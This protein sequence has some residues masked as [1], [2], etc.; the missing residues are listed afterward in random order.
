MGVVKNLMVRVG[1]D[2]RGLV[3]GMKT[4]G[5]ATS[6]AAGSIKNASSG[7]QKSVKEN[8][9]AARISVREY[10]EYVAKTKESHTVAT[11]NAER[12]TDKLE[13]LK[14]VFGTVQN[15]TDG[16]DMS[17]PLKKQI[18]DTEKQ[19]E[20]INEKIYRTSQQI[21]YIGAG[22]SAAKN[23]RLAKLKDQLAELMTESD[24]TAAHLTALD[25]AAENV[26]TENIDVASAA[27]LKNLQAEIAE[28][29]RQLRMAQAQAEKTGQTLHSMG[30]APTLKYALRQIGAAAGSAVSGGVKKLS[31][32][33][34][35]LGTSA[36]RGIASIPGKLLGIGKSASAST[37][38]L[39]KMVRSIRNIG[40]VSMGMKVASGLFGQLR[41]I[42]SSYVSQNETLNASVT[43][44]KNQLGQA[45]APAINIV[46]AAMQK[47]MPVVT[48]VANA[49]NSMF[50]ALF[51]KVGATTAAITSS[52][53]AA[54]SAADSL[55]TYGFDQI[56]KVSDDSSGGSSSS[57]SKTSEL[58]TEQ[59]ALIQKL[60]GWIQ[61][62]K[63]AFVAGDWEGL[64]QVV[65][66]GIN[67]VFDSINAV[68]VGGK[69]GTFTNNLITTLNSALS[70]ANFFDIGQK[71]GQTFTSGLEK[72]DWKQAG[73]TIGKVMT[74]LPSIIIGFIQGTNWSTVGQSLSQ[75]LSGVFTSL[76]EWL[77]SVDW[78]NI[79]TSIWDFISSIDYG[80]I[81]SGLFS[82]LGTALGAGV[83]AL[84]GV[85]SG[86]VNSIKE[87]FTEKIQDCGGNVVE[88]LFKGILDA[89]G[90]IGSWI[91]DNIFTPFVEGFKSI[92]GIHSPSTV[93]Q[94]QGG[95]L[96]SGLFGGFSEGWEKLASFLS[97]GLGSIKTKLGEAWTSCRTATAQKWGEISS[98]VS[99]KVSELK[100]AASE[101]FQNIKTSCSEIW[102]ST[103]S[104]AAQK[105]GEISGAVSGKVSELKT[106][107]SEKFQNIK[108]SCSEIWSSMKSD[109]ASAASGISSNAVSGFEQMKQGI[110]DT[111]AGVWTG[112][113]DWINKLIGG[114]ESMV[115]FVI[116]GINRMI[117]SFNKIASVGSSFGINL[118]ISKIS[119]VT[120]PRLATGGIAD[121]PTAAIIG[122]AGKEAVL[123]LEGNNASWMDTL[124]QKIVEVSDGGGTPVTLQI[125]LGGR[126]ITEY[127]IKDINKITKTTGVC[128]IKV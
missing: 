1:A 114:V 40:I 33:L 36:L 27:G 51:G 82:L 112:V 53:K 48:S 93:M 107:A 56:T 97:E 3:S 106:A 110:I 80:S 94:E 124:V 12:L 98:A 47:L 8:F 35:S 86:A 42:I 85:I 126:K 84:W 72:V 71:V 59:S 37:G 6:Q 28:V 14:S 11:Q 111:F 25:E 54:S 22:G 61:Q 123:P 52:A 55:E 41:S 92:F 91:V 99:G 9:S 117:D 58:T 24:S 60:T 32:G 78:L 113:K 90:N 101:K 15:A 23:A 103:K 88:G 108:T 49:V 118:S 109:T 70:T 69:I 75:L 122:E 2:V 19:L 62:L 46:V 44:L 81:A 31:S 50:T 105:W 39:S 13:Q 5:S 4:A 119:T 120:L 100:T 102:S 67:S 7:M 26:G 29:E 30:V 45:L 128:P 10:S 83:S 43:S 76:G 116:D 96:A 89:L 65:G 38:G 18:S 125:I 127:F 68:D 66:N 73:D 121:G 95:F 64:G 17:T 79:G 21:K 87:Y 104:D 74:M 20:K 16:L 57:A 63:N 77:R 115:N 34:K